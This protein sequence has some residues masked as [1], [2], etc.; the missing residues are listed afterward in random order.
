MR[1]FFHR[2]SASISSLVLLTLALSFPAI[3]PRNAKA[4]TAG[5]PAVNVVLGENA[6]KLEQ[7]AAAELCRYLDRL[8]GLKVQPT[9]APVKSA[10]ATFIV[11][12]P[13]TNPATR[14]A[15]GP[16]GW[17]NVTDQ[18]IVL[19]RAVLDGKPALV[20]GGGSPKATLWAVYELVERWGVRYLL[21]GDVLPEK[22]GQSPFV[23]STLRAVPANGDCPLFSKLPDRDIVLE[24]LLRVRQWRVVN[25]FANGTEAWGM[26]DYRPFLD[27]LT[28]LKFNRILICTWP[29]QPFVDLKLKGIERRWGTLWWDHRLPITPDMIGRE[30]FGNAKEFWNPDLPD[31][32]DYQALAAA[33]ERLLHNLM[34]YAHRRGMEC[35]M[36]APLSDFPPEFASLLKNSQKINQLGGLSIVP[37]PSTPP[38]DPALTELAAAV[39][40]TIVDTYPELDYVSLRMPEH[41]QWVG[42]HEQAWAALD[43]KYGISEVCSLDDVLAAT[44]RR[45]DYPGGVKRAVA[46]VKGDLV[47]LYFY[48]RL[49]HQSQAL[50]GTRRP[51]M[52]F[53]YAFIAE[54]LYPLLKRI[55]PPGSE[56]LSFVDYTPARVVRRKEVLENVPSGQEL[57]AS[58]IFTL[59]DDNIGL[60]PQLTTGSLHQ[61]T[62]ELVRNDWAGFSTR[63]WVIGG[64]DPCV[65]YLSRAAWDRGVTPEAVYRDQVRAVCGAAC[66]DD[67]L[68]MF[69]E[70]EAVTVSLEWHNLSFAFPVPNTL[71]KFHWSS[72][73]MSPELVENRRGYGRALEAAKRAR[74]KTT[75]AGRDYV[76]YWVGRLEFAVEYLNTVEAVRRA[77]KAD[78]DKDRAEAIRQAELALS[79]ARRS[80]EAYARVARDQS[81]RG[82][83]AQLNEFVYR[84]LQRKLA[85]LRGQT[86]E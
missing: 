20:V 1:S 15:L 52:K 17:P 21:H 29:Y 11:G 10:E 79:A 81:D 64:Q 55:L 72:R 47:T 67:M 6:P 42:R 86:R 71:L 46:E 35:V 43:A 12:G 33:G 76:D 31:R 58:L 70:V 19:K 3:G 38:E 74:A 14:K 25:D 9:T 53:I 57:P 68:D 84:S 27:Q 40:R 45:K 61:L 75:E 8:Y 28:K 24:P 69:R 49:L 7:F 65:A 63:C 85:A 5:P 44:K 2:P 59:E 66:V 30:L 18:G 13:A 80:I 73:P 34:D 23:R 48:D 62:Q 51:D 22:R 4:G 78:R 50:R 26:A 82:A 77:A 60:V 54:E 39:L 32:K 16:D 36:T 41:R 37:G 56:T 83:I